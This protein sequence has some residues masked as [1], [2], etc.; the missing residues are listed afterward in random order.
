MG[1]EGLWEGSLWCR[2]IKQ[3]AKHYADYS[4]INWQKKKLWGRLRLLISILTQH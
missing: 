3:L 4:C 1:L 2:S